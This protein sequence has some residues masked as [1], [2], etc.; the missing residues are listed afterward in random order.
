MG[1]STLV[2]KLASPY[3]AYVSHVSHLNEALG[4]IR[5]LSGLVLGYEAGLKGS[6]RLVPGEAS[7]TE[8]A[9][10]FR[11]RLGRAATEMSDAQ[12]EE[13][14]AMLG[15]GDTAVVEADR[16]RAVTRLQH[17]ARGLEE[18]F[19]IAG[20]ELAVLE[21]RGFNPSQPDV[22]RYLREN[23]LPPKTIAEYAHE[24]H[25]LGVVVGKRQG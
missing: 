11:E 16:A 2:W 23:H 12:F 22:A 14:L 6:V 17:S 3:D 9:A 13:F 21:K 15:S 7:A 8:R 4:R 1:V 20:H 24:L 19:A 10:R 25:E 18:Y 5:D